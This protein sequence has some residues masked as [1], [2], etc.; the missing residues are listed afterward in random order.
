ML[1]L[2]GFILQVEVIYSNLYR[3][4]QIVESSVDQNRFIVLSLS[5]DPAFCTQKVP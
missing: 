2:K 1:L 4:Y 5:D 3:E